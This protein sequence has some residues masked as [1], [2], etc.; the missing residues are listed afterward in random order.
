MQL[1][2]RMIKP[3][4]VIHNFMRSV[5]LDARPN[6]ARNVIYLFWTFVISCSE[7]STRTLRF[8]KITIWKWTFPS[9]RIFCQHSGLKYKSCG[10]IYCTPL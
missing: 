7:Q 8:T 5:H 9:E 1:V 10:R 3:R 4:C 2:A 6:H